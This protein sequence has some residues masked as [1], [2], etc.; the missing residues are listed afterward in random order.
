MVFTRRSFVA[1][2]GS[3]LTVG[4]LFS[5]LGGGGLGRL[6]P[7]ID[8]VGVA[9]AVGD[10]RRFR[11]RS[12]TVTLESVADP[13]T[14]QTGGKE[15]SGGD[16]LHITADDAGPTSDIGLSILDVRDRGLTVADIEEFSYEWAATEDDVVG[17]GTDHERVGSPDDVWFFLEPDAKQ[18]RGR[19]RLSFTDTTPVFRTQ[20]GDG[21]DP[22]AFTEHDQ[23]HTRD[24]TAE[25]D[26]RG[27][28]QLSVD[29]RE[30]DRLDSN[31]RETYGD[32]TV[33][34]VGI[35]R[36]DPFWG[37]STLDSY[38]RNLTLAGE[39]YTLPTTFNVG[40]NGPP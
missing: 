31:I 1:S 38:Y 30:F 21:G 4:G 22:E 25:F 3:G 36:G 15:K 11:G 20:Y 6:L 14:E 12:N 26:A 23:W 32:A 35:S 18:S 28:K 5:E 29:N 37:P 10:D 27:W 24:V 33:L 9:I 39:A 2:V 16:V 17:V 8:S 7:P 34:G 40:R 19:G 13:F